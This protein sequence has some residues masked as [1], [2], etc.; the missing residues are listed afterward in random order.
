MKLELSKMTTPELEARLAEIDDIFECQALYLDSGDG[1]TLTREQKDILWA[2]SD[3]LDAELGSR[4]SA[5]PSQT[6]KR[7]TDRS[8]AGVS[9]RKM[10]PTLAHR[11]A[12]WENML[13]TV[14]AL[15]AEGKCHYFDYDL[16]AAYEFAGLDIRNESG[17]NRVFKVTSDRHRSYVRN[18]ASYANPRIGKLVLWVKR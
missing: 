2:A 8:F 7:S 6:C 13:G 17:D 5:P 3:M 15:N 1:L 18:A 11:P 4:L 16:E 14:F 10:K 12:L 9:C